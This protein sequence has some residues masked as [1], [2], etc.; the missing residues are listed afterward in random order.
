MDMLI[1]QI[2]YG[3]QTSPCVICDPCRPESWV[4]HCHKNHV[5]A[6][7][8]G[9]KAPRYCRWF[10]FEKDIFLQGIN[11]SPTI[12]SV[13]RDFGLETYIKE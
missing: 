10:I 3:D 9:V 8:L 7:D 11:G 12:Q 2:S 4:S 13:A 1:F 6:T 5:K